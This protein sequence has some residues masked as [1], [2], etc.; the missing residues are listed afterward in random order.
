MANYTQTAIWEDGLEI[1][2]FAS[3][4]SLKSLNHRHSFCS[5]LLYSSIFVHM[6]QLHCVLAH[7]DIHFRWIN[8]LTGRNIQYVSLADYLYIH[9]DW[10]IVSI[11]A[12]LGLQGL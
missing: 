9:V 2:N 12:Y 8:E 3:C 1:L 5:K 4:K 11:Y 10:Q 7:I 6:S